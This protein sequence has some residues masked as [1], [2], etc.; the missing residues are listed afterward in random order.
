MTLILLILL[1]IIIMSISSFA[2]TNDFVDPMDYKYNHIRELDRQENINFQ[3]NQNSHSSDKHIEIISS[4]CD[5]LDSFENHDKIITY[6]N[7]YNDKRIQRLKNTQD[8]LLKKIFNL[9]ENL[10]FNEK[11]IENFNSY[12]EKM[13][14]KHNKYS[15]LLEQVEE[16]QTKNSEINT[17]L[18]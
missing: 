9:Q 16:N 7:F 2:Y 11:E 17:M 10:Y 12:K 3:N 14:D 8:D 5:K 18:E 13:K 4:F 15:K 1:I 6:S